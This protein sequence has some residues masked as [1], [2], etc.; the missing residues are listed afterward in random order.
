M[1]MREE[2]ADELEDMAEDGWRED[3]GYANRVG[4]LL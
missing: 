1:E 4:Q 3:S 2:D